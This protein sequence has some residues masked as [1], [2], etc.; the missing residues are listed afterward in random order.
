MK[1]ILSTM[2]VGVM[3]AAVGAC[4]NSS[5]V[6]TTPTSFSTS[7]AASDAGTSSASTM[8]SDAST[9]VRKAD[10]RA[11]GQESQIEGLVEQLPPTTAPL[12]FVVA[13]VTVITNADTKFYDRGA[14]ATFASLE[15]GRR[16]H[17]KGQ[18]TDAGLVAAA[19]MMQNPNLGVGG[20][21]F[22]A[23]ITSVSGVSPIMQATIGAYTVNTNADTLVKRKGDVQTPAAL[24]V[25]MTVT[26][27][28]R[29][30]VDGTVTAK[31]IHIEGDAVGGLF[32]MEGSV[33]NLTG[34]CQTLSF[35]VSGYQ[36]TTTALTTFVPNCAALSNGSKVIVNGVVQAGG[37]IQATRV[38]KK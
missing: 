25:G 16:V 29:L 12:T 38:E 37:T 30:Q 17:V 15:L 8:A 20:I 3:C 22:T 2:L 27:I 4:Q 18:Q 19:V 26:V 5:G 36:I 23:T 10:R 9:S 7:G 31:Q 11:H 1:R 32:E 24:Q 14:V 33:G 21:E 35:K 6:P 28:G 13:G 34:T